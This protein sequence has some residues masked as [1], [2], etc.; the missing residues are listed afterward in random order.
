[1]STCCKYVTR[2]FVTE[3]KTRPEGKNIKNIEKILKNFLD[4]KDINND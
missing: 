4:I 2:A 3:Y 1:M